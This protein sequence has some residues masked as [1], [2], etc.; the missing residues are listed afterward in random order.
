MANFAA[1]DVTVTIQ[2]TKILRGS[3]GGVRVVSAKLAF[4][5][6]TLTYATGGVPAPLFG[7]FGFMRELEYLIVFDIK[8]LAIT[9]VWTWD[10]VNK[11]LIGIMQNA[12][13]T[14]VDLTEIA[15]GTAIA[16]QTLHVQAW[17]W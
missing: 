11:K 15:N 4:G 9:Y 5:D 3:P 14:S 8:P 2:K 17:G 1:T 7:K 13:G 6:A 12:T 16:A 10:F